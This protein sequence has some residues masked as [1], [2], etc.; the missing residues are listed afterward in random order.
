MNYLVCLLIAT[1]SN[2]IGEFNTISLSGKKYISSPYVDFRL[3]NWWIKRD[4]IPVRNLDLS[5]LSFFSADTRGQT[6]GISLITK[7]HNT[8]FV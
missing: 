8:D 5:Y 1:R 6:S 3:I 4:K 7:E 2:Q